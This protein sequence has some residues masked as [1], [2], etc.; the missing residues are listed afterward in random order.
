MKSMLCAVQY[1][2]QPKAQGVY[3]LQPIPGARL[4]AYVYVAQA[5]K[6][7]E[8]GGLQSLS[9]KFKELFMQHFKRVLA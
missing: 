7:R 8:G 1:S 4:I 6:P 5:L 2:R 3:N 9:C